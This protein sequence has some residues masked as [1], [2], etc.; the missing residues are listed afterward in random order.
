MENWRRFFSKEPKKGPEGPI[1]L[2]PA[3][4]SQFNFSAE[5]VERMKAQGMNE[6]Q[7]LVERDRARASQDAATLAKKLQQSQ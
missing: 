4:M 1:Q 6:A 7:I 5:E 3:E 2:A